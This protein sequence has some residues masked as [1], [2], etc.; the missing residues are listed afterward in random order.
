MRV[1]SRCFLS[2]ACRRVSWL[3]SIYGAH[4]LLLLVG[5]AELCMPLPCCAVQKRGHIPQEDEEFPPYFD[6]FAVRLTFALFFDRLG[7]VWNLHG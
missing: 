7:S 1:R 6:T 5:H 3:P 2:G 4:G